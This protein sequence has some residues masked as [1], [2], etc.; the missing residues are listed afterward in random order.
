M[1]EYTYKDVII[2]PNDPRAEVGKEY[3]WSDHPSSLLLEVQ[4]GIKQPLPLLRIVNGSEHPFKNKDAGYQCIIRTKEPSYE[5]RQAEWVKANNLKVGDKVRIVRKA[6]GKEGGW[7]NYWT[8]SMNDAV[9]EVGCVIKALG[10][11]GIGVETDSCSFDYPYF[12]LKKVESKYIPFDL[13][14]EEDRARLRGAWIRRKD[15]PGDEY[16]IVGISITNDL[17]FF[18]DSAQLVTEAL[19]ERCEFVDGTPCGKLEEEE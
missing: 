5:E 2:D 16:Q 19:L 1:A 13:G 8:S 4:D 10:A 14:K 6:R 18:D 7:D 3:Y 12:V 9:G 11:S 15:Y 17:V